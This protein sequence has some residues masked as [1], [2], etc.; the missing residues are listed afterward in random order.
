VEDPATG[1]DGALIAI[2]QSCATHEP[3][4]S[5]PAYGADLVL[6]RIAPIRTNMDRFTEA[7]RRVLENH[8]YLIAAAAVRRRASSVALRE[9]PVVVPHP[10]WMDEARVWSALAKSGE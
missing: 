6:D 7:E 8:G 5:G 4:W 2:R 1:I 3:E 10:E 9:A